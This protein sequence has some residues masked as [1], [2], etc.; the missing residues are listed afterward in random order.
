MFQQPK[1]G[2]SD[3]DYEGQWGVVNV[4]NFSSV[5]QKRERNHRGEGEEREREKKFIS[6]EGRSVLSEKDKFITKKA[7]LIFFLR[8]TRFNIKLIWYQ[9]LSLTTNSPRNTGSGLLKPSKSNKAIY[10]FLKIWWLNGIVWDHWSKTINCPQM[11]SQ[12]KTS[13]KVVS[14]QNLNARGSIGVSRNYLKTYWLKL[15]RE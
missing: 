11:L 15:D 9:L 3:G 14:I 6:W 5:K 4:C 12:G 8:V 2:P 10:N 1:F 13:D 7:E